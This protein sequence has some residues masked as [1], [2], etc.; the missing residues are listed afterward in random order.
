MRRR[1][2]RALRA[3][4]YDFIDAKNL[5]VGF[6]TSGEVCRTAEGDCTEH[7][8]LLAAMLRAAGYPAR[9]ASG[10]IYADEFVGRESIFGYHAWAQAIVTVDGVPVWLDFDATLP[11]NGPDTDATHI[12]LGVSAMGE[13]EAINSMAVLVPLIGQLRITVERVE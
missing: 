10:L 13:G 2:A 1:R 7:A 12:L 8:V 4:V 5:G 9:V 3:F 11:G 6:A